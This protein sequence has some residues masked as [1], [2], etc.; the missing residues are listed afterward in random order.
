[1]KLNVLKMQN[2][3]S[4][5]TT[6]TIQLYSRCMREGR[7]RGRRNNNNNYLIVKDMEESETNRRN[8]II[9]VDHA[10]DLGWTMIDLQSS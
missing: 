5:W 2:R 7:R 3:I 6:T 1:M 8:R 4:K 9:N 10:R